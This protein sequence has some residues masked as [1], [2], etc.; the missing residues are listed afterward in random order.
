MTK[1]KI[2]SLWVPSAAKT[3][4]QE[5]QTPYFSNSGLDWGNLDDSLDDIARCKDR[6]RTNYGE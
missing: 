1:K 6:I 5:G 4:R 3:G 2:C